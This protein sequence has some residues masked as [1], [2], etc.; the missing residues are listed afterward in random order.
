MRLGI[1]IVFFASLAALTVM[2]IGRG[3][4]AQQNERTI[5]YAFVRADCTHCI[6]EKKFFEELKKELPFLEI[7]VYDLAEEKNNTLFS[8]VATQYKLVKGT[9]ITLIHGILVQG[10]ESAQTTGAVFRDLIK[11]GGINQSFEEILN[12]NATVFEGVGAS[13]DADK[14][15]IDKTFLVRVPLVGTQIDVGSMPLILLSAVLG[16]IDGFNPCAMWVLV[17]FLVILSQVGSR[18]RMLQ[19]AG[20]FILAEA[21]MYYLI[22]TVWITAWDFI[23]LNRITLPAVG[24]LAIGSGIYFL[25]KFINFKPVCSVASSD[26][27][28]RLSHR[29]RALAVKPLTFGVVLG[30]LGLAFSVNIFEFACSIGI[31]Q[32]FT[33]IIELNAPQWIVQQGYMLVYILMYMVDDLIVFGIA[34]YSIS[35][36]GSTYTYA[37]W[38]SL[39]GGVLM[40]ILGLLLLF[41]PETLVF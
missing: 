32:T 10:F 29:V 34:L 41:R 37:K 3:A 15:C 20:L 12:G 17:M 2:G 26:Q 11:K 28:E 8:Q 35:K 25:Y 23:A 6:E 39:I 1:R 18:K 5:I 30:I 31:P 4:S 13:C 22:L 36:I 14:V 21:V 40:L 7:F 19:Y 24:I 27:Q 9:P 38:S 16:F 33:K